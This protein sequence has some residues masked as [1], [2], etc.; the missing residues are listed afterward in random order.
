MDYERYCKY[1][2]GEYVQAHDNTHHKNKNSPL[3]L[4]CVYLRPMENYQGSYELLHLYINKIVKR[5]NLT[6]ILITPSIIKQ[7]HSLATL[8][9][10][11]HIRFCLDCRSE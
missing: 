9:D 10:M 5:Q 11:P 4:D 8:D 3:A 6:K 1:K 2:V 7:V